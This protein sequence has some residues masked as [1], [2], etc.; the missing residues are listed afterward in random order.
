MAT[1][2]E[3]RAAVEA[4]RRQN[5]ER[6]KRA[7]EGNWFLDEEG[8]P[9]IDP[10]TAIQAGL[11]TV[12]FAATLGLTE[13]AKELEKTPEREKSDLRKIGESFLPQKPEEI[14]VAEKRRQISTKEAEKFREG[15]FFYGMRLLS[16]PTSAAVG[17]VESIVKGEPIGETVAKR[18]REGEGLAGGGG[19]IGKAVDESLGTGGWGETIG[20]GIGLVGEFF[21]PILPGKATGVKAAAG[22]LQALAPGS[23]VAA[24][25]VKTLA[26]RSAAAQ[27]YRAAEQLERVADSAATGKVVAASDLKMPGVLIND[28]GRA[29][30]ED[31]GLGFVMP[32]PNVRGLVAMNAAKRIVSQLDNVPANQI[33][34]ILSQMKVSPK[35]DLGKLIKTYK[36]T[37]SV[38]DAA[39][40]KGTVV[41]V[42]GMGEGAQAAK[43][44]LRERILNELTSE[45]RAAAS[46]TLI[47]TQIARNAFDQM[48]GLDLPNYVQLTDDV[49]VPAADVKKV[50]KA[51]KDEIDKITRAGADSKLAARLES[52]QGIDAIIKQKVDELIPERLTRNGVITRTEA[53]LLRNKVISPKD[54]KP[55]RLTQVQGRADRLA[56]DIESGTKEIREMKLATRP[57][58]IPSS[59]A[60]QAVSD[61]FVRIADDFL[62]EP[63]LKIYRGKYGA[64]ATRLIDEI[65]RGISSIDENFKATVRKK[66]KEGSSNFTAVVSTFYDEAVTSFWLNKQADIIAPEK[67]PMVAKSAR[68]TLD[69][70]KRGYTLTDDD[71]RE[72]AR[73]FLFRFLSIQFGYHD[74]IVE[75]VLTPSGIIGKITS[76]PQR[77]Q[78]IDNILQTNDDARRAIEAFAENNLL[79]GYRALAKLNNI[80]EVKITVDVVGAGK[81]EDMIVRSVLGKTTNVNKQLALAH[82]YSAIINNLQR[83]MMDITEDILRG[84]RGQS[85]EVADTLAIVNNTQILQN[86]AQPPST[87]IIKKQNSPVPGGESMVEFVRV[88]QDFYGDDAVEILSA[89]KTVKDFKTMVEN[90]S[91]ITMLEALM[92]SPFARPFVKRAMEMTGYTSESSK[93]LKVIDDINSGNL[94]YNKVGSIRKGA[95]WSIWD[96]VSSHTKTGILSGFILPNLRYHGVNYL[97]APTILIQTLGFGGTIRTLDPRIAFGTQRVI[98]A[99]TSGQALT[100]LKLL[101]DADDFVVTVDQFG[102]KYTVSDIAT[103]VL[104]N[105]VLQSQSKI[106]V[107]QQI[108]S[109]LVSWTRNNWL[110]GS[111]TEGRDKLGRF[112]RT[113]LPTTFGRGQNIWSEMATITDLRWRTGILIDSLRQGLP[114]LEA[115]ARAREALFDYGSVSR[116]EREYI[117]RFIWFWSFR[118]A[119]LIN[120]FKL[121]VT[122]P[123]LIKGS[124]IATLSRPYEEMPGM[125]PDFVKTRTYLGLVTDSNTKKRWAAYGPSLPITEGVAELVDYASMLQGIFM[126]AST[127]G[128]GTTA[129]KLVESGLA[130]TNPIFTEVIGMATG[131]KIGFGEVRRYY[132]NVKS[133]WLWALS[134]YPEMFQAF[135]ALV[136]LKEVKKPNKERPFYLGKQWKPADKNAENTLRLLEGLMLL[137]GAQRTINDYAKLIRAGFGTDQ[138]P[139][140]PLFES[141]WLGALATATNMVM[142]APLDEKGLDVERKIEAEQKRREGK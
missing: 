142:V 103:M 129:Q 48:S 17:A 127:T 120:T 99:I 102:R 75:N 121:A 117:T 49:W 28:V 133:E 18:I 112:I 60:Y 44:S 137:A 72:I 124:T 78:A 83:N 90:T 71:K 89:T 26:P 45:Q 6:K 21:V 132:G 119:N 67:G 33:D 19:Q 84:V 66:L 57:G 61:T 110:K 98:Q 58:Q 32:P 41:P 81:S 36:A 74:D 35:S 92:F 106:E 68:P 79:E 23:K 51:V 5:A 39:L 4:I 70:V 59:R 27:L 80:D 10:W 63:G 96:T 116:I 64:I 115:S 13:I 125:E 15:T 37:G 123:Q 46:Q 93:V 107:Q 14:R 69:E 16:A 109:E 12:P 91:D 11:A 87:S 25:T 43:K 105:N 118:R 55:D 3:E 139:A 22:A 9:V 94:S 128:I 50:T 76:M 2:A 31:V 88:F 73:N 53:I 29:V 136:P 47:Q 24:K 62:N 1:P 108:A 7:K 111:G 126:G 77:K 20:W 95:E 56:T 8:N 130:Q 134:Q 104:D 122:Q 40:W 135:T 131:T 141:R 65:T 34:N 54:I 101:N 97:T 140:D 113:Y 38:D 30:L 85:D 100:H 82:T 86:A 42:V 52:K 138:P 114:P